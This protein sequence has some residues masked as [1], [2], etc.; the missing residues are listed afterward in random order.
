MKILLV[1]SRQ[2]ISFDGALAPLCAHIALDA[3]PM[4]KAVAMQDAADDPCLTCLCM[5]RFLTVYRNAD[6]SYCCKTNKIALLQ[7]KYRN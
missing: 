4:L 2:H 6:R 1:A 5:R 7:R 3:L